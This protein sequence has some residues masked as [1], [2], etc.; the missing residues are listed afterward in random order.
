MTI[1]SIPDING[2]YC[3]PVNALARV[4]EDL[5]AAGK[6]LRGWIGLEVNSDT[7]GQENHNVYISKIHAAGPAEFAGLKVGDKIL[8]L[9]GVSIKD[10]VDLPTATF[11]TYINQ[12]SPIPVLRGNEV[13]EFFIKPT[14]APESR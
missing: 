10:V 13:L 4:K 9:C 7:T 2:S 5:L 3:L 1:A 12:K 6:S 8:S 14:E 11:K